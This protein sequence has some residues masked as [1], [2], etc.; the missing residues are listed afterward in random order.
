MASSLDGRSGANP[1]SSPTAVDSF[2]VGERPAKSLVGLRSPPQG[3]GEGS[4]ADGHDH[5]LL[6]VDRVVGV[7][8][9]VEDVHHRD[10]QHMGVGSA[11]ATGRGAARARPP[12]PGPPRATS[13]GWRWR[14][15]AACPA[16]RRGRS[17]RGR[18]RAGRARPARSGRPGDLAVDVA[19]APRTPLPEKRSSP[20]RRSKASW[21][22]VDAPDGAMARPWAPESRTISTSTVG[23]PRESSTSRATTSRWCSRTL[24]PLDVDPLAGRRGPRLLPARSSI[25]GTPCAPL[26]SSP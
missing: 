26:F 19:T 16:C 8:A 7:H 12:R 6:E 11:D 5:E 24:L 17:A 3:L 22:P 13:P 1:P 15:A 20:S 18:R 21:L 9:T 23:L 14:P 10:R 25:G 4:R 2:A